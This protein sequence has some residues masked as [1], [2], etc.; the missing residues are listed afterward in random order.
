MNHKG[1]I[2]LK[3]LDKILKPKWQHK[4][5]KVRLEAVKNLNDEE[6]LEKVATADLDENI[7]II[8]VERIRN[9]EILKN[10][11]ENSQ[12]RQLD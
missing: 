7:A 8:A 1:G 9:D 10:I 2:S 6:K 12:C 3:I 5:P 4:D 11:V